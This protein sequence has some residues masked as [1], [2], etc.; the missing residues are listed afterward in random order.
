[1]KI[2]WFY[3]VLTIVEVETCY[4]VEL[5][6]VTE[7]SLKNINFLKILIIIILNILIITSIKLIIIMNV[8]IITSIKLLKIFL[9]N[10]VIIIFFIKKNLVGWK[11]QQI[12][13][14]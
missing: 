13:N 9:K 2:I 4:N 7:D 14:L 1:M 5:T 11:Y 6:R 10:G 12:L 3:F 8:L